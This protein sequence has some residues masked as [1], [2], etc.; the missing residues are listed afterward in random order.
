MKTAFLYSLINHLKYIKNL[1][2]TKLAINCDMVY[3]LL[4]VL[5]NLKQFFCL[6][7]KKL[8]SLI[9]ERLELRQINKNYSIFVTNVNLDKPII[10]MFIDNIKIMVLKKSGMIK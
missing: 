2:K 7:Y 1:I 4:K 6:C 8:L 3:K 9:F 5:Y 10:N